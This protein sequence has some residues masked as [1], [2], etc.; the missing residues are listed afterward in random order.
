LGTGELNSLTRK[1]KWAIL[2]WGLGTAVGFVALALPIWADMHGTIAPPELVYSLVFGVMIPLGLVG[3]YLSGGKSLLQLLEE[4]KSSRTRRPTVPAR[5]LLST[6]AA[7]LIV[8][9]GLYT[10]MTGQGRE[11]LFGA[12]VL[13]TGSVCVLLAAMPRKDELRTQKP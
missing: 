9:L 11:A 4:R 5:R 8:D 3:F 7:I 1:Q 6:L 13:I 2:L 10:L 12:A